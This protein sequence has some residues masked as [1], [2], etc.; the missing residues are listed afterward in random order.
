MTIHFDTDW[1]PIAED[2]AVLFHTL[3]ELNKLFLSVTQVDHFTA[4]WLDGEDRELSPSE[5]LRIEKFI[6][7][8]PGK[9][10][11]SATAE[12]AR[13]LGDALSIGE[14]LT[15][16]R[17]SAV[18]VRE[19]KIE[20]QKRELELEELQ[21]K[22]KRGKELL[23]LDLRIERERKETELQELRKKKDEAIREQ[24]KMIMEDIAQLIE[25]LSK[26]IT[27]L[28]SLPEEIQNGFKDALLHQMEQF[29]ST[30]FNITNIAFLETERATEK[31]SSAT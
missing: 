2:Y 3:A 15:K 21:E 22:R 7:A 31:S 24:R 20:I 23:D 28:N 18:K 12:V 26:G 6:K 19:A 14:Q 11:A 16:I 1:E 29:W 25:L 4:R 8:S 17:M 13:A 5:T 30:P 9:I 27:L 10:E